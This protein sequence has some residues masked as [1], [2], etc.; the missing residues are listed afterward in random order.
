MEDFFATTVDDWTDPAGMLHAY[1]VPDAAAVDR[2]LP[3]VAAVGTLPFL[4][5][6]PAQALHA[7]IL[8]LPFRADLGPDELTALAAAAAERASS[9]IT[10]TFG[11]PAPVVNSVLVRATPGPEWDALVD[12]VR[13]SAAAALGEDARRYGPPFGPHMTLAYATASGSDQEV[14]ATL[15]DAAPLGPVT[16]TEVAWCAVHQNRAEGTYTFETVL[17][18]PL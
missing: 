3:S 9:P 14:V 17:T 1:L 8:R 7:T 16:F 6:Q 2:L 13:E 10:L 15:G 5:A 18:T 11:A 4:A 12:H